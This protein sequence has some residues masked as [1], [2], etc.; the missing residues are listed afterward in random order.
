MLGEQLSRRGPGAE[1]LAPTLSRTLADVQARLIFRCQV[2][3]YIRGR[4][5]EVKE[6]GGGQARLIFRCQV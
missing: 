5:G 4:R 3:V 6:G 2:R 1:A